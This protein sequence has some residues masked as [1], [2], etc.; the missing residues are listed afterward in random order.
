MSNA[1]KIYSTDQFTWT[2]SERCFSTEVSD[3]GV[4]PE[5]SAFGPVGGTNPPATGLGLLNPATG[6]TMDFRLYH[7]E[8]NQDNEILWWS[9]IQTPAVDLNPCY[10]TIYND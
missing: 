7:V 4:R 2:G 8:F 5:D 6:K 9:L 10:V 1:A 3:L